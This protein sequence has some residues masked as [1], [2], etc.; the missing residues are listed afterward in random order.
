[1]KTIKTLIQQYLHTVV[2]IFEPEEVEVEF[3]NK[4]IYTAYTYRIVKK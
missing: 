4:T 3:E 2:K 1:M